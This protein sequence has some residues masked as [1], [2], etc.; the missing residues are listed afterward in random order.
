MAQPQNTLISLDCVK[1]KQTLIVERACALTRCGH[2][3]AAITQQTSQN[4]EKKN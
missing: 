4:T 1:T 2:M 3:M